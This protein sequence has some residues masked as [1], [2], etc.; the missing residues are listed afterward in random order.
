MNRENL[1]LMALRG[2]RVKPARRETLGRK[3]HRERKVFKAHKARRVF[4]EKPAQAGIRL[5]T[6]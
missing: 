3:G 1:A 2:H 4:K 6:W 5:L